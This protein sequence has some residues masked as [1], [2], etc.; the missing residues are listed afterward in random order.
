MIIEEVIGGYIWIASLHLAALFSEN[1][2]GLGRLPML[3]G[4]RRGPNVTTAAL[5][6]APWPRPKTPCK[7]GEVSNVTLALPTP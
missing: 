4:L 3:E 7:G 6:R 2:T 5:A 1:P